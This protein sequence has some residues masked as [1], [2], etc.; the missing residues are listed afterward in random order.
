MVPIHA[1]NKYIN[2]DRIHVRYTLKSDNLL[3]GQTP[4]GKPYNDRKGYFDEDGRNVETLSQI[5]VAE[6]PK[7]YQILLTT[8]SEELSEFGLSLPINFMGKKN[9]GGWENQYLLN[10]PY[11]SLGNKYKYCF[12]SNPNG[13]NLMIFP[14]G[15]CDGWKCDYSSDFC[16]G[17]FFLEL[18]FLANFDRAYRTKSHHKKLELY[19][20]EVSSFE[21]G[22]DEMCAVLGVPALTFPLSAVK[23]GGTQTLCVHGNCDMVVVN[24]QTYYPEANRVQVQAD[25]YGLIRAVPYYQNKRGLDC[26]FYC[27]DDIVKVYKRAL[28]SVNDEQLNRTDKNLCEHHCWLS[29]M[30]RYMQRYG[31]KGCDSFF[32]RIEKSFSE[33]MEQDETKAIPRRTVLNKP[34]KN[35]DS[36]FIFES[37]RIQE[38]LFGVTIFTDAYKLTGKPVFLEY[39]VGGLNSVLSKHFDNGM[40]YTEYLNGG[41]EDYTTVCCLII[42]FVDMAVLLRDSDPALSQRFRQV[43][44]SIA[45]Y[46][47]GRKGI[48]TEAF[49]SDQTD[50]EMED[51]SISCTALS[52]LYYCA[53]IER[54]DKYIQRAKEILDLHD[55]WISH[56]PI[57][58]CYHSTLRWW[59]T[60]WNGDATGPS[61]CFG[62][63]WTIW[64]AEAD[65]WYYYLTKDERYKIKAYNGFASN[66]SKIGSKGDMYSCYLLDYIPGG[67]FHKNCSE[68]IVPVRIGRPK[69][70]ESGLSR[71]ALVRAIDTVLNEGF[72]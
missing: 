5:R 26:V 34:Y 23:K 3:E 46:L 25:K 57:A 60:F 54:V 7:G 18:E 48:H 59:E 58:P 4:F 40:I 52:L 16:P 56:T 64:R 49:V 45:A 51:G 14:K 44:A 15:K 1:L 42:P 35:E 31:T 66:F 69:R 50:P 2:G 68:K 55:A 43:S 22:L 8:Q 29:A 19:V 32:Q 21:E 53:K 72:F 10:S 37:N 65:Y 38:L 24:N 70:R 67:G 6:V 11:T 33:I 47:Y 12:L 20:L 63:A 62:H 71:Y 36:Y 61:I 30:L 27:Y 17:H 13:K 28:D 41:K 39:A 9:G